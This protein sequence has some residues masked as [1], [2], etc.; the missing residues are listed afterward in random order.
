MAP[1]AIEQKL[2]RSCGFINPVG[3]KLAERTDILQSLSELTN[4]PIDLT[5]D[6]IGGYPAEICRRCLSTVNNF[7]VFKK[8]FNDGQ[9]KLKQQFSV[10]QTI[11]S[12]MLPLP[13]SIAAETDPNSI[14][15]DQG[16]V[17][18]GFYDLNI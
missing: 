15:N 6:Q 9:V 2:C 13:D 11:S 12:E 8:T 4:T 3:C 17:E 10:Q 5:M 14:S 16:K 18:A 7:S 1:N